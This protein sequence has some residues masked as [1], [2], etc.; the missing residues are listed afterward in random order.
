MSM[1]RVAASCVFFTSLLVPFAAHAQ[2]TAKA[3]ACAPVT[4]CEGS[5][6]YYVAPDDKD[7]VQ[8][9]LDPLLKELRTCLDAAGGKHVTPAIVI[10]FDSD[11]KPVEMKIEAGGYESLPCIAEVQGK[12]VNARSVRATS[13]RCEYGCPKPKT[14]PP[15][16]PAPVP[17]PGPTPT[18]PA[19]PQPKPGT[20]PAPQPTPTQPAPPP[21]PYKPSTHT[22]KT[23][24]GWQNLVVDAAAVTVLAIGAA[25]WNG[26]SGLRVAG[27]LGY[28]FGSPVVHWIHGNIGPGFGSLGMR[29][30]LPPIGL[31]VGLVVGAISAAGD[32]GRS[33]EDTLAT[34]MAAG[35][36]I[37]V[38]IPIALDAAVLGWEKNEVPNTARAPK[39]P[40][41]TMRPILTP[42]A[43]GG[44]FG[45]LGGSF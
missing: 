14:S 26:G 41:L 32:S 12:L 20:T 31:V 9:Q 34:A 39:A 23:W 40:T 3:P 11:S 10:R 24:Y 1:R 22:E 42:T 2:G 8:P 16:G 36:F 6:G 15:V 5:S 19:Q 37:G 13:M 33:N 45:G 21:A 30:L 27:G 7:K 44:A 25:N 35:F 29:V 18:Q 43:G 4:S 28:V 38:A 17:V